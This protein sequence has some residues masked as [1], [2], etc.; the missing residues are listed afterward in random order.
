[1]KQ[2]SQSSKVVPLLKFDNRSDV[3][4]DMGK[5]LSYGAFI[6]F[7]TGGRGVGKTTGAFIYCFNRYIK[8]GEQFIYLKRY[9][10]ELQEFVNTNTVGQMYDNVYTKG[11]G[12][13]NGYSVM[14]EDDTIGY[15]IPLVAQ[16]AFKSTMFQKVT[17]IVFDEV[18][19]ERGRTYYLPNEV[20]TLLQFVSTVQRTR[21]NLRIILLSN[22][23]SLYNPYYDYWDIPDFEHVWHNAERGIYC[24][25]IP[26]NPK[27]LELEQVTPLYKLTA[28]TAYGDYHYS[29]TLLRDVQVEICEKPKNANYIYALRLNHDT[30]VVYNTNLG[31][32]ITDEPHRKPDDYT[33]TLYQEG[34]LVKFYAMRYKQR[35]QGNLEFLY[36]TNRIQYGTSKAYD[37]LQFIFSMIH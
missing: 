12:A 32:W 4:F 18:F 22:N 15:L 34:K 23:N 20:H 6:N 30:L 13:K 29:N 7:F 21:K 31:F 35:I 25:N 17:T 19:L 3:Y 37:M 11:M 36:G 2:H 5:H 9:K 16:T 24:E 1:M 26:I 28:G 10:T 8:K 27:L 33:Y 14:C